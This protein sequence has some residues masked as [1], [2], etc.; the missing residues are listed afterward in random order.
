MPPNIEQQRIEELQHQAN[1]PGGGPGERKIRENAEEGRSAVAAAG[2]QRFGFGVL[3][4]A[5]ACLA[6]VG[7]FLQPRGFLVCR[8]VC[9]SVGRSVG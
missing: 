7:F 9:R 4:W 2:R 6:W 5:R 1:E 3:E 8:S